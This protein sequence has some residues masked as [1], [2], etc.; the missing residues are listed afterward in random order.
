MKATTL[1][2]TYLAPGLR[3]GLVTG[4]FSSVFTSARTALAALVVLLCATALGWVGP[5]MAQSPAAAAP[6]PAST[7]HTFQLQNGMTVIVQ[8]DRRAPTAIHMVW[9]RAGSIDET[10]GTSGVAHV[11][12]H[13]LFKG[14]ATLAEG[15]FSRRVAALGG[16]D[17]AFTSRDVTAYH[18]QVPADRLE[19]V[20]K[21]EADRFA[22][23]QW[24]DDAFHRELLVVKEERRQRVEE[25]PQAR[26]FEAFSATAFLAHP[27]RRPI[28]G[29]MSDIESLTAADVRDFY[30]R[31]Y[32]PANAAVVVVGDVDVAQVRRWAEE[33]YGRIPA[34]AVPARK[35]QTE[36][37]QTGVRRLEFKA[38]VSQPLVVMGYKVPQLASP[39]AADAASQDALALTLLAGVLDG[40]SAARLERGLV[41]GQGQAGQRKANSVGASFGLMGRGPQLFLL[42]GTPVDG[43]APAELE[44]ALKREVRRVAEEGVSAA[45]LQRVKNQWSASE[46]FKLDSMFA[47]ARELGSY[48]TQGWPVDSAPQLME[49]LRSVT[50]EQVQSVAK[51][52]FSDTQLTVGV[53]LPETAP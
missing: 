4:A 36:P 53:L 39:D 45:E 12:E 49:R 47:Q 25:S 5:S 3:H 21:L 46:I 48:W 15:E 1:R 44:E 11:L 22:N 27:Y 6:A 16:R 7:V 2:S 9:V 18:Q 14:T 26:L 28:I 31:W 38:R 42:T 50:A 10:D 32:V 17:N 13:M 19:D 40:H 34:G 37:V 24:P 23:N 52:Y 20:M 30:R 8:P 35:P 51:R 33:H 41:Q 29:W 43:V